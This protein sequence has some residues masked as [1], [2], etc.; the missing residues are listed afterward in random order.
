[1]RNESKCEKEP[2][3]VV[4]LAGFLGAGKTTLLKRVLSWETTLKDTVVLV[5]EFGDVGIDGG[6]L[7]ENGADMVELTSGCICC[8]LKVGL[9][10]ALA[11]IADRISP[12]RLFIETTGVADPFTIKEILAEPSLRDKYRI[13]KIVTVLDA[14]FWEAREIFGPIFENQLKAANLILLNKIDTVESGDVPR[15][16]DEIHGTIPE[17][18]I[19]P[20]IHCRIDPETFF[21][22]PP[23]SPEDQEAIIGVVSHFL[24]LQ[25]GVAAFGGCDHAHGHDH[26]HDCPT[27]HPGEHRHDTDVVTA[28]YVSFSFREHRPLDE[29]LFDAFLR[30]L[31]WEVFRVKGDVKFQDRSAAINFVGGKNE[32]SD[33]PGADG[34]RLAFVGWN[35][36]GDNILDRLQKC[37][38][39]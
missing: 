30:E 20:T 18:Q 2:T 14:D 38:L 32:V 9:I 15:F 5:N 25:S 31:P 11:D 37:V 19:V 3:E 23:S 33:R 24:P 28:G 34:T 21:S 1:M 35:V 36:E 6:L 13:K 27:C 39:E 16:L 10:Q 8:T 12:K 4:V 26:A 29:S 7:G 17:S 22:A